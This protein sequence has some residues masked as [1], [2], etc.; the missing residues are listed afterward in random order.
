[1]HINCVRV[2]DIWC[3]FEI[4]NVT[5]KAKNGNA[6]DSVM[7]V[8]IFTRG[9]EELHRIYNLGNFDDCAKL[10]DSDFARS[11]AEQMINRANV[12]KH[13]PFKK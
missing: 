12:S 10:L 2:D 9:G 8:A 5:S 11:E 13:S 6:E 3:S 7:A 1:M 4:L